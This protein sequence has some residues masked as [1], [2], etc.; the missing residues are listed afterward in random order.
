MTGFGARLRSAREAK[1]LSLEGLAR[2]V[3][4]S[5]NQVQLLEKGSS[6]PRADT[7]LQLADAVGMPPGFLLTGREES[8]ASSRQPCEALAAFES[9]P[10]GKSAT[11]AEKV[12]IRAA[13]AA[14][15]GPPTLAFLEALLALSRGL[16]TPDEM[17][18]AVRLSEDI[19]AGRYSPK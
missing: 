12:L 4:R 5:R 17:G 7:L 11:E 15:P 10:L 2:L 3:G 1:G 18:G 6:S 13:A 14:A 16:I 8:G 9:R 19:D